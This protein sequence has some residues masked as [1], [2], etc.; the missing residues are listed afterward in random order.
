MGSLLLLQGTFPTQEP[1]PSS[2]ALQ[3][4]SLL[5]EPQG[6][7]SVPIAIVLI[8]TFVFSPLIIKISI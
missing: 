1:K 8:Q 5:A 7:P 2:S 4:D 3:A 6:K